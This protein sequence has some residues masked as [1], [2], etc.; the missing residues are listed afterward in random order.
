MIVYLPRVLYLCTLLYSH[1]RNILALLSL[2]L[3]Y[4]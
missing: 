2:K 4:V 3:R 1:T